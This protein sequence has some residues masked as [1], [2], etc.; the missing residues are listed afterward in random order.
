VQD[1]FND[2][3]VLPIKGGV[4]GIDMVHRTVSSPVGWN[5]PA[6]TFPQFGAFVLEV[7]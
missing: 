5:A 4:V 1:Y 2:I 7:A 3:Q 6:S